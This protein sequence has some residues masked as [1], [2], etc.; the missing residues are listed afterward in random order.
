MMVVVSATGWLW[1][2]HLSSGGQNSGLQGE[3]VFTACCTAL[4]TKDTCIYTKT[5]LLWG[6]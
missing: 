3:N 4:K 1:C 5:E 2:R 6:I